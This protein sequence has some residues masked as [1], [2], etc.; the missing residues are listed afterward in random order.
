MEKK[1]TCLV[2]GG[3]GFI[4]S[5]LCARL[6]K[7]GYR[8]VAVDN[9]LTGVRKNIEPLIANPDFILVEHDVIQPLTPSDYK[10]IGESISYIYHFASPASPEKYRKYSIQ[11][12]LVN[13]VGTYN[14]L[15]L[16]R[17]K[18]S[19]FLLAS[20]SEIYGNP[21]EH[22]QKETYFGN[23]NT[24]GLRSCYDES[25][26]FAEA[27]TSEYVRT[28][29]VKGRIIRIFNTFGPNMEKKDGRVVSNFIT[30][31]LLGK[32]LTMYGD[33]NQTRSLCFVSDLIEGIILMME[34]NGLD[35]EVVNLGN[36]DEM[37]IKEIGELIIKL[38]KSSSTIKS[39]KSKEKDDPDRRKPDIAKAIQLLNWKP[40]VSV[41]DGLVKT[42]EYFRSL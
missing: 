23:V 14:M 17:L 19:R 32:D 40:V 35:G 39:V 33:G 42:I 27:I 29:G 10:S 5:H 21:L 28:F 2:T 11:T 9:F 7:K 31:A 38:T 16:A 1:D 12:L 25:K 36:P 24:I 26:R 20:T 15:E 37:T 6:L 30:Q 8:V 13:S 34:K 4:G 3:A 18:K 41:S 22:P